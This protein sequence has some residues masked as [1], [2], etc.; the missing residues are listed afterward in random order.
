VS[1]GPH[2]RR[3]RRRTD[4]GGG[5]EGGDERWLLTYADM[6]T[7]LMALFI[8]MWAISSVNQSK[9]EELKVSLKAAFSGEVLPSQGAVL[10]GGQGAMELPGTPVVPAN[11]SQPSASFFERPPSITATLAA[12]AGQADLESLKRVQ[13]QIERYARE[14]GMAGRVSTSI[15]ERGLEIR[16]LTDE[17]MFDPGSAALKAQSRPLLDHIAR[18]LSGPEIPNKVRVEGNTD[19]MPIST[20]QFPSNWELSTGRATAVLQELLHHGVAP[21]RLSVTGYADQ[22]PVASNATAD[23]RAANRHVSLVVLRRESTSTASQGTATP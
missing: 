9:F 20:A 23:G 11:P 1:S 21:G 19:S 5:H 7:L 16:L 2:N 8:V 12:A 18:L 6:I 15:D 10:P 22:R 14:H 17:L 4:H 13:E 3:R